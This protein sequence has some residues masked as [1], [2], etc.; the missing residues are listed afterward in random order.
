MPELLFVVAQPD[1]VDREQ[2]AAALAI[3]RSLAAQ[4]LDRLA[5]SGLLEV[6]CQ[7]RSQPHRPVGSSGDALDPHPGR[8]CVAIR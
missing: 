5:A 1:A 8:C 7:R 6:D 2:V 4:H 3:G